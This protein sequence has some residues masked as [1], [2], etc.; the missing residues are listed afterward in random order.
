[1][2]GVNAVMIGGNLG[3][4]PEPKITAYGKRIV[5]FWMA[6]GR[7]EKSSDGTRTDTVTWVRV[8]CHGNV[9]ESVEGNLTKGDTVFVIGELVSKDG[10]GEL[11]KK[12]M[13]LEV[14]ARTVNFLILKKWGRECPSLQPT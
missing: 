5:S 11:A 13:M 10:E 3:N 2:R 12:N 6:L 9:A 4:D 14:H 7:K 8:V 1:M